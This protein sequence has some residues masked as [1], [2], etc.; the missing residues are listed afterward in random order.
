MS[1]L[2]KVDFIMAPFRGRGMTAPIEFSVPAHTYNEEAFFSYKYVP[3]STPKKRY[4]F[5][6][7]CSD[8][9]TQSPVC[10]EHT[11]SECECIAIY[12]SK[13]MTCPYGG[14]RHAWVKRFCYQ[15]LLLIASPKSLHEC[16]SIMSS[17]PHYIFKNYTAEYTPENVGKMKIC[18]PMNYKK[19]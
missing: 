4:W 17:Q 10:N 9:F 13:F 1:K 7:E 11:G 15:K 8:R 5:Q 14:A 19:T 3:C 12:E 16:E 2:T 18:F 6:E